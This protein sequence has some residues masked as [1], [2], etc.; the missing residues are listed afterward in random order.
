M[1][2]VDAMMAYIR[3]SNNDSSL[4]LVLCII[5]FSVY[6]YKY[7]VHAKT[8]N[9]KNKMPLRNGARLPAL[10]LLSLPSTRAHPGNPLSSES[11]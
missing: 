7:S 10:L 2:T 4:L 8:R 1:Q 6:L 3:I 9:V 5:M 11:G